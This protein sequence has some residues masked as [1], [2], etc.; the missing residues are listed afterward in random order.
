[1][2][3]CDALKITTW[4]VKRNGTHI[5]KCR[6]AFKVY[7]CNETS[8]RNKNRTKKKCLKIVRGDRPPT[9]FVKYALLCI[10]HLTRDITWNIFMQT[11]WLN[12]K[13]SKCKQCHTVEIVLGVFFRFELHKNGVEHINTTFATR[14]VLW[15]YAR[16]DDAFS[17]QQRYNECKMSHLAVVCTLSCNFIRILTDTRR[18]FLTI[19]LLIV[20]P[21]NP[22][23]K[24]KQD[25]N[26]RIN[27]REVN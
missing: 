19:Q 17:S 23:L 6:A 22:E 2:K 27:C 11:L 13:H 4:I 1:M 3:W 7:M 12:S 20:K 9:S 21:I 10:C 25:L 15:H 5:Q 18:K 24:H 16:P 26:E 14:I 8:S